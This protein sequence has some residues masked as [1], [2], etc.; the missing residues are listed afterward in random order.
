MRIDPPPQ[1]LVMNKQKREKRHYA[2]LTCI[3]N[4]L[5]YE[6]LL[7]RFGRAWLATAK[8]GRDRCA[9]THRC[10]RL[11]FIHDSRLS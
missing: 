6:A 5:T 4:M 8:R 7:D 9:M 1:L 3:V 10:C 2:Y 11:Q